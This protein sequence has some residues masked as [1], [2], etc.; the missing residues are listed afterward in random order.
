MGKEASMSYYGPRCLEEVGDRCCVCGGEEGELVECAASGLVVGGEDHW[1]HPECAYEKTV[2]MSNDPR[3]VCSER[4]WF[5]WDD[6][7]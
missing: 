3:L 2:G 5:D 4:C 7:D 6:W 1:L